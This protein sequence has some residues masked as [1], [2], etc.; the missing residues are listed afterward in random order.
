MIETASLLAVLPE[1]ILTGSGLVLML[2]AA[3]GGDRSTH[4]TLR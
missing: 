2:I 1:L 3:F 4:S